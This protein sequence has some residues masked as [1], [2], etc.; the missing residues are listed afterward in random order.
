MS[1]VDTLPTLTPP[2]RITFV[3]VTAVSARIADRGLASLLSPGSAAFESIRVLRTKVKA[4]AEQRFVHCLGLVSATA[5]EGTSALAV[6]LA[7]AV[8]Q[9]PD[10]RVLLVEAG[11]RAP[12]LE[13]MLGLAAEPGLA[14]WLS[15]PGERAL[16]LRRVEPWGFFLLAGGTPTPQPVELLAGDRLARLLAAAAESFDVVLLDCPS[17]ETV[18]DSATLQDLVDGF[19]LVVRARHASRDAIR[20][21]LS[22]LKRERV[23]GVVLNDQTSILSRWLDRRR[24]RAKP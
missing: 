6:G 4:F 5:H 1:S 3:E 9:E 22:F 8:A 24:L 7:A 13:H 11:L 20:R 15:A 19:L 17:L 2:A 18:A 14:D 23:L 16:P 12:A 21:S 10:R